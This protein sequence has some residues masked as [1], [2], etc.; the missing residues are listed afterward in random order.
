ML[1]LVATGFQLARRRSLGAFLRSYRER[2]TPADVGLPSGGRRRTPGLRREEVAA[3]AGVGIS[4]Y[5]WLEQ[6]RVAASEPVLSSVSR[7]LRLDADASR[8]AREL[9][10]LSGTDAPCASTDDAMRLIRPLLSGWPTSPTLAVDRRFDVLAVNDAFRSLWNDPAEI[11]ADHRNILWML[12]GQPDFVDRMDGT[13]ELAWALLGPFR[14]RAD[15]YPDDD[16]FTE[17]C[18]LLRAE[19]PALDSWWECRGVREF[20]PLPVSVSFP[21]DEVV[22][23]VSYLMRPIAD[24]EWDVLVFSP[25]TSTDHVAITRLLKS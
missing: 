12:L 25:A 6:G 10:G 13:T 15:R 23:F 5:A 17:M 21:G 4:W 18:G 14:A 22:R 11:D 3:L 24:Q 2:L 9:A 7:V 1:L 16:R 19:F 20:R 8:H